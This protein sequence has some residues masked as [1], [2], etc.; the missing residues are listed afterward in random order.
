MD[1]NDSFEVQAMNLAC[2][3]VLKQEWRILEKGEKKTYN[4]RKWKKQKTKNKKQKTKKQKTKKT[5]ENYTK[6][7]K[8]IYFST[9]HSCYIL[10][11][12]VLLSHSDL[13]LVTQS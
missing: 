6:T 2:V 1:T 13:D 3:C 11:A 9:H 4:V 7:K 12:D 10:P 8:I 5:K